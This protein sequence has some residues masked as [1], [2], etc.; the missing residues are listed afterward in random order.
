M[1]QGFTELLSALF[2]R[3]RGSG[4][5][6]LP[7]QEYCLV[8]G[9]SLVD[10]K[11]YQEFRVCPSCRFH[12]TINARHRIQLLT[13]PKSFKEQFRT[14]SSLDPLSFKGKIPYRK[15]IFHDQRRTGLTEAAIVGS[16]RISGVRTI[17]VLLDFGFM[18]G[19]IGCVVG[20]KV[21]LAFELAARKH[22]PII[23]VVTSG[24][25]RIQE[26]VLSLMQMAKATAAADRLH[27]VKLPYIT[28][29]ANPTTG[30][31]YASFAN[32]ADV[33]LAEPGSLVGFAP[34]RLLQEMADEPLPLEAHT[35][36]SHLA[37]GMV[38]ATID[39][40]FLRGAL[41][42][43]LCHL[44]PQRNEDPFLRPRKTTKPPLK[45]A[46]P[47]ET[48]QKV[49][50]PDR[51]TASDYITRLFSGFAELRGDRL[52]GND[53]AVICGIGD[54]QGH[55]VM[56]IGQQRLP[57]SA[58]QNQSVYISPEGFRK[59][60]RA[61]R[62]ASKFALPVITLL[63]TAGPA[64]S[65]DAEERG[66][67]HA[68]ASTIALMAELPVPTIAVIVG[69]GG[70]EGALALGIADRILMLEN[71]IFT[72]MSPEG[73]ASLMYRDH[74]RVEDA[75][76]SLRLTAWDALDMQIIND[77]VPEPSGG[78]HMDPDE[79]ALQ[80][81]RAVIRAIAQVQGVPLG[82]LLKQRH[83][84][85]RNMGE[86]SSYF[87][88]TL[89][90]E[91][92]TLQNYVV[93]QFKSS[94]RKGSSNGQAPDPEPTVAEIDFQPQPDL[95]DIEPNTVEANDPEIGVGKP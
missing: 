41:S 95:S 82:R 91:V 63:D 69:E 88:A 90:R 85:F 6:P 87:K 54:F 26:G 35:A 19:S 22:L 23:A 37:H 31:A 46:E 60:Q 25:A 12:Y 56:I 62:L 61:M 93:Q 83:K 16:C 50:R 8:C 36:E 7:V 89:A 59:A 2:S 17:L 32:L 65:L 72:P 38:D 67:G 3:G 64:T 14:I 49:R 71:A 53:P 24:G 70:R 20:E 73:A 79:A 45:V 68:I 5:N 51:P 58:G 47:W 55:S 92:E 48:V 9:I 66:I 57:D 75:A 33:L 34:L 21:T 1:V 4:T 27:Q 74:N 94:K 13:D 10:S 28:V 30:Q 52:S 39:R 77:I 11:L 78:A 29:F 15:L 84:K 40:E 44:N 86:Y 81:Q 43:L 80:L 42:D 76:R 18:G